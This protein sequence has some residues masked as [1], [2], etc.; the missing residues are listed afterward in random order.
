VYIFVPLGIR[1]LAA[2]IFLREAAGYEAGKKESNAS[3]KTDNGGF[4]F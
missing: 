3:H 2:E 4:L 1:M